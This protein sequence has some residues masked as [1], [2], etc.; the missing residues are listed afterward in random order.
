MGVFTEPIHPGCHSFMI[1][2]CFMALLF[3]FNIS[4]S[5]ALW[6]CLLFFLLLQLFLWFLCFLLFYVLLIHLTE[7]LSHFNKHVN[8]ILMSFGEPVVAE[9]SCLRFK[10]LTPDVD[11]FNNFSNYHQQLQHLANWIS[12]GNFT[13]DSCI[14]TN[15]LPHLCLLY[16]RFDFIFIALTI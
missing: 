13:F 7:F 1:S 4:V 2:Y 12:P 15:N 5:Q 10:P 11:I 8:S 14:L 3:P 9:A 16:G 6:D